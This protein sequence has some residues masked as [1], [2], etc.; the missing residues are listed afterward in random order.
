MGRK[1]LALVAGLVAGGVAVFLVESLSSLLHPIPEGLDTRDM[2]QM[3]E[4]VR[5]LP[6]SAFAM[7]LLAHVL[8]AFCAGLVS[9]WVA[10]V[11]WKGG[12]IALGLLFTIAGIANLVMIPH[13]LW[14][15]IIDTLIYLPAALAGAAIIRQHQQPSITPAAIDRYNLN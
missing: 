2:E 15:G 3:K 4:F 9:S 10:G 8:G 12:A 6:T 11:K 5:G 7:V 13:P 1:V 14:F